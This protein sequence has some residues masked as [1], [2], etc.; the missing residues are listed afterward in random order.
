MFARAQKKIGCLGHATHRALTHSLALHNNQKQDDPELEAI[1]QR[2][3]AELMAQ[4]GG[5]QVRGRCGGGGGARRQ[6][7]N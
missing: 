3:M 5:G 7:L 2:R 1:R 6:G 4:Q